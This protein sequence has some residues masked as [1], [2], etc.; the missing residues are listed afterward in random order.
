MTDS[1]PLILVRRN[2]YPTAENFFLNSFSFQTNYSI[3]TSYLDF[4]VKSGLGPS[5]NKKTFHQ[6]NEFLISDDNKKISENKKI[7][8]YSDKFEKTYRDVLMEDK[9]IF[10]VDDND[11]NDLYFIAIYNPLANDTSVI[12]WVN[13]SCPNNCNDPHGT[14]DSKKKVFFLIFIFF[15]FIYFLIFIFF[16]LVR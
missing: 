8:S 3:S 14:C 5:G 4:P 9:S 13:T 16:F 7:I 6:K 10:F 2:N 11:N 12:F 15:L 1:P